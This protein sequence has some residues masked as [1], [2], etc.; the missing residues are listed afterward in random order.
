MHVL[1]NGDKNCSREITLQTS[2]IDVYKCG[3]TIS[4]CY[5][6]MR[7]REKGGKGERDRL[8]AG[9]KL[10]SCL[11][12]LVGLALNRLLTVKLTAMLA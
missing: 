3:K 2:A 7:E 8:D 10:S 5:I 1:C 9:K 4:V 11:E 12:L 6:E